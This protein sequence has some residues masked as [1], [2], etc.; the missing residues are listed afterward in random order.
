MA[1]PVAR[2]LARELGH[3]ETWITA[4]IAAFRVLA[5]QYSVA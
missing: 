4:Q 5:K 1:E 3:D 2:L